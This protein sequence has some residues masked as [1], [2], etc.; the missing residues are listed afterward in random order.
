M[1]TNNYDEVDFTDAHAVEAL[2][3]IEADSIY[4]GRKDQ[5]RTELSREELAELAEFPDTDY[6][7]RR[8]AESAYFKSRRRAR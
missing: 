4:W 3:I 6:S 8:E 2:E 1:A 5:Q 7:E